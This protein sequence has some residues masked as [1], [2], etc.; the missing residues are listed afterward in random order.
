MPGDEAGQPREAMPLVDFQT[1]M[2]QDRKLRKEADDKIFAARVDADER[3]QADNLIKRI[4]PCD[5]ATPQGVRDWLKEIQLTTPYSARTVYIAAQSATG[6]LRS[7]IE[8]YLKGVQDRNAV[9]WDQLNTYI[10]TAFLNKHEQDRLKAA[11]KNC[12][13]G[14]YENTAAY[15]RRF[16]EAVTMA[17]TNPDANEDRMET[18]LHAYVNGLS[19]AHLADKVYKKDPKTF[20]RAMQYVEDKEAHEFRS[21]LFIQRRHQPQVEER[22]EEPMDISAL[23]A[24]A[25]PIPR[26]NFTQAPAPNA[27]G[28]RQSGDARQD[29]FERQLAGLQGKFTEFMSMYMQ[30]RAAG[31]PQQVTGPGQ[32]Q[33]SMPQNS[34]PPHNHGQPQPQNNGQQRSNRHRRNRHSQNAQPPPPPAQFNQYLDSGTPVCNFCHKVGHQE[35]QCRKKQ[36]QMAQQAHQA[37]NPPHFQGN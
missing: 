15:G 2:D 34:H 35:S 13:Q 27:P 17:Y 23:G 30:D 33:L 37:Q 22:H 5:G 9:T 4:P 25:K 20:T 18:I 21:A 6:S 31:Q 8:F 10:E 3:A 36:R 24:A 19:D 1:Y 12:V 28:P 11:V 29:R 14:A 7:N 26:S 32:Q 16:R